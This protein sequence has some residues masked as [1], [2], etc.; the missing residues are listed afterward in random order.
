VGLVWRGNPQHPNDRQR[1]ILL[2]SLEPLFAVPGVD[3]YNLQVAPGPQFASEAAGQ[4]ALIPLEGL[5]RDFA[6]TAGV[7]A[8]LDLVI[9]ADTSVAHLA[10]ALGRPAWVLLP[11]A[12]DWRWLLARE[13]TPW[14]PTLR[15]FRQSAPGDWSAVIQRVHDALLAVTGM[16]AADAGSGCRASKGAQLDAARS[17]STSALRGR[18]GLPWGRA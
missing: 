7:V 6:D 12:P 3:F 13:D 11:F 2:A 18:S 15:L 10:G 4:P 14:Y 8:Q 5:L 16:M 9:A 1:S 17:D